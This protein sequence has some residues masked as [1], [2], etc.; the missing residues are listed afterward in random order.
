MPREAQPPTRVVVGRAD[1]DTH[2]GLSG[3]P[4]DDEVELIVW[5]AALQVQAKVEAPALA[6]LDHAIAEELACSPFGARR[7]TPAARYE[8]YL[9][10]MQSA[11]SVPLLLLH[12]P[13]LL[14]PPPP[15]PPPP[16]SPPP[17]S[18]PPPPGGG[19][20]WRRCRRWRRRP[21]GLRGRPVAEFRAVGR[22]PRS[23][24]PVIRPVVEERIAVVDARLGPGFLLRECRGDR[25]ERRVVRRPGRC[26][27]FGGD[28]ASVAGPDLE[29][30][31]QVR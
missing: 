3:P 12:A 6:V 20:R 4:P 11:M 30:G 5:S 21:E 14:P 8:G 7:L 10:S 27:R 16:P 18:P 1:V 26:I 31:R 29:V 19:G 22:V 9:D 13:G 15:P 28:A 25:R 24:T 2:V 23:D 17:P